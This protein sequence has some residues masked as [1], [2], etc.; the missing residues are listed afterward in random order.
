[1]DNVTL[2]LALIAGFLSFVSP[3]V[4]PLVPAYIGYM[5]GRMTHNIAT[6][7]VGK[8]ISRLNMLMHGIAFVLGFTVVFVLIGLMTT[9][10]VSVI[11]S[12]VSIFTEIL[13]RLGGVLIIVF[14]L[15]FMGVIPSLVRRLQKRQD[16]LS[17]PILSILLVLGLSV[18]LWWG[19]VIPEIAIPAIIILLVSFIVAGAFTRPNSFWNKLLNSLQMLLFA[20]TRPE[21]DQNRRGLTGSFIM[22]VVFSA[23]WTPCIG[24]LLGT[25][26]TLAANTGE[27]GQAMILLT[28]YSLG[29]GIPFVLTALL[30]DSMQGILRKLQS[31]M[32]VI[33]LVS[34]GLLVLI[35]LLVASG[36]LQSLSQNLSTQFADVSI[37]IEECGVGFAEGEISFN[38]LGGCLNGSLTSIS[39][40]QGVIGN[41]S[42]DQPEL[43]YLIRIEEATSVDVELARTSEN[44]APIF[45]IIDENGTVIATSEV[46]IPV[47]DDKFYAFNNILLPNSGKYTLKIRQIP[48]KEDEIISYR[49][50]IKKTAGSIEA[51][52]KAIGG[53]EGVT[54]ADA[55][56]IGIA[57]TNIAPNFDLTLDN[58]ESIRLADYRGKVVLLNFWGTWCGPCRREMPEF[59]AIY[60]TLGS[61]DFEI[62][63]VAV[64]DSVEKVQAFRE[65]FSLTFLMGVEADSE[66]SNM[67]AITQQPSSLLISRDGIILSRHSGMMTAEQIQE[68]VS[69]ALK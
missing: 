46:L 65:E 40:G 45:S 17:Q 61:E 69:A 33:E 35:G 9:A 15:Q 28:M 44:I 48:D 52:V 41:L 11:G 14:G 57:E 22:G 10:F 24:P 29:L 12:A 5:G 21:M 8:K 30:M 50:K 20:D 16:L 49:L 7:Q 39:L 26:L 53:I 25:I 66:I 51:P 47:D 32:R 56:V 36:Q 67:Y 55:A 18:V 19:L 58:G 13:A 2:G 1:M 43:S 3:C 38:E 59:Q 54:S 4:L 34:G 23:G 42:Q 31:Y 63:A 62:I 64:R 27:V 60:E 37:R 68:A 6:E